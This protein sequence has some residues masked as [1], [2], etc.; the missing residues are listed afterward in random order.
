MNRIEAKSATQGFDLCGWFAFADACEEQ[1]DMEK[2]G[3]WRCRAEVGKALVAWLDNP[4][5]N[6]PRPMTDTVYLPYGCCLFLYYTERQLR[7]ILGKISGNLDADIRLFGSRTRRCHVPYI[8][9][10]TF[11]VPK[12]IPF[13]PSCHRR[14][15]LIADRIFWPEWNREHASDWP[16]P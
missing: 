3:L 5:N 10:A 16:P 9:V 4:A 13:V 1:G 6:P 11:T 12:G 2:A 14:V 15:K 7:L 8:P